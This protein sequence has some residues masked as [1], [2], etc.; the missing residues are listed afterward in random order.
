MPAGVISYWVIL[1]VEMGLM[2][3][4]W[5]IMLLEVCA[6]YMLMLWPVVLYSKLFYIV[7]DWVGLGRV[8]PREYVLWILLFF[9]Y[10]PDGMP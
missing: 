10:D 2:I 6:D 7:K 3:R 4:L 1:H 5:L 9:M 8:M